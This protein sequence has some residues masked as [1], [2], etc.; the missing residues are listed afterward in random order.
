[1]RAARIFAVLVLLVAGLST[2]A[3][4]NGRI[5]MPGTYPAKVGVVPGALPD[6]G[7]GL[8]IELQNVGP[9]LYNGYVT[10]SMGAGG[11]YYV[12]YKGE[13]MDGAKLIASATF[14]MDWTGLALGNLVVGSSLESDCI[15]SIDA[16]HLMSANI[17]GVGT[18]DG[19]NQ[20][21]IAK[22]GPGGTITKYNILKA[23]GPLR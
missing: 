16:M 21:L 10:I 11:T 15:V 17:N 9:D 3:L 7:A 18:I 12:E 14:S 1:M 22:A 8:P 6:G 13:R 4:A 19:M 23:P 20:R 5:T 2:A